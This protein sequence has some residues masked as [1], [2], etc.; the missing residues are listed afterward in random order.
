[1]KSI[2][3][4]ATLC[5]PAALAATD[6]IFFSITDPACG[7]CLHRVVANGPGSVQ[8]KEFAYYLCMGTGGSEVAVCITECGTK[9]RYSDDV[10][11]DEAFTEA[12]IDLIMGA[13]FDYWYAPLANCLG[14]NELLIHLNSFVYYPEETCR[15]FKSL[16]GNQLDK[17]CAAVGT[18]GSGNSQG[19]ARST[20]RGSSTA[21]IGSPATRTAATG[22]AG[23][24]TAGAETAVA[25][26]PATGTA[27]TGSQQ[28]QT[29][30]SAAAASAL[31]PWEMLI[32]LV[33]LAANI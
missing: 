24:G 6:T 5:F 17:V 23:A 18:G 14:S 15:A 19:S 29:P 21:T 25:G 12:Q 1:M 10:A 31:T 3:A 20:S 7:P 9:S 22:I 30:S 2:L 11:L 27:A 8:S 4:V 26:T 32:G 28:T 16:W 13:V 33:M